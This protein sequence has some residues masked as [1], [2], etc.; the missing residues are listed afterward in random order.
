MKYCNPNRGNWG[1][2]ALEPNALSSVRFYSGKPG[3]TFLQDS[4][5]YSLR[6]DAKGLA[7]PLFAVFRRTGFQPVDEKTFWKR[8]KPVPRILMR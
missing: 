7:R 5:G 6:P 2:A 8:R 3:N 1:A 4:V